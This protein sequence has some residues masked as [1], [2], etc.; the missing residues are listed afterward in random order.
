MLKHFKKSL[1]KSKPMPKVFYGIIYEIEI[2][3][4][5]N[6]ED[7]IPYAATLLILYA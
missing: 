6:L 4:I 3:R 5:T 7:N 1:R 2:F